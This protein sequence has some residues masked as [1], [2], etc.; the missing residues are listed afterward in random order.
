MFIKSR[1]DGGGGRS[2][3]LGSWEKVGVDIGECLEE[4]KETRRCGA[5]D[6]WRWLAEEARE[7]NVR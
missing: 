4:T 2:D 1:H 5:E 7:G 3:S 6:G